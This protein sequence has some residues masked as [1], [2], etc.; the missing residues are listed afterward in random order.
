MYHFSQQQYHP[1]INSE[2][3]PS[4][5][6]STV[7]NGIAISSDDAVS[8]DD[9]SKIEYV[10]TDD[11]ST[12]ITRNSQSLVN[13]ASA[14]D[15][16]MMHDENKRGALRDDITD[17]QESEIGDRHDEEAIPVG[18]AKDGTTGG[19]LLPRRQSSSDKITR[20]ELA[21]DSPRTEQ[22]ER[23]EN[24]NRNLATGSKKRKLEN[25]NRDN[26]KRGSRKDKQLKD[27]QQL[28]GA[29]FG[30]NRGGESNFYGGV[31]D[32]DSGDDL[33]SNHEE[34]E[35]AARSNVK[36]DVIN[37][38]H[39]DKGG[40]TSKSSTRKQKIS[41]NDRFKDLMA[42]KAKHG[43]CNVPTQSK[44]NEYDPLG[45]WCSQVRQ[46]Y[47]KILKNLTPKHKLSKEN[48]K[49]LTDAGFQWNLR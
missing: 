4:S 19:L 5:H 25:E 35:E 29:S 41:F 14:D 21:R 32:V 44:N 22:T 36:N 30:A 43:H 38:N 33:G 45:G 47:K 17:N 15:V 49:S 26:K 16:I 27:V 37:P 10:D 8:D 23:I 13:E 9:D 34:E 31:K 3:D 1:H 18:V 46:S 12:G 42:F 20:P 24:P 48:I 6:G 7:P 11:N 2:S 28:R 40:D 39:V